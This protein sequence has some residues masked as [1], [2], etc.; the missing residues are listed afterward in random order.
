MENFDE[1][2]ERT[3][4]KRG[5]GG[6]QRGRSRKGCPNRTTQAA[7]EVVTQFVEGNLDRLQQWLD[8]VAG[9]VYS[10]EEGKWIV[11]PDP[12]KAF[13][14]IVALMEFHIPK[15]ARTD[16]SVTGE[17][18]VKT[19]NVRRVAST[20]GKSSGAPVYGLGDM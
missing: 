14:M 9:G 8:Q 13:G 1:S 4:Q 6:Y 16:V 11:R 3:A 15:L 17:V 20:E 18:T 2:N 10:E 12:E 5:R 19:F 7:R